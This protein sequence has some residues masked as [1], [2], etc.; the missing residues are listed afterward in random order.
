MEYVQGQSL[1][2]IARDQGPVPA[3]DFDAVLTGVAEALDA[4]HASGVVHGDVTPGNVL[5]TTDG[6][7]KLCDFGVGRLVGDDPTAP[8]AGTP[9][10]VAP[11]VLNGHAAGPR[12]DIYSLGALT[13]MMLGGRDADIHDLPPS[14]AAVVNSALAPVPEMRCATAGALAA[15][16]H[17]AV[18]E[19]TLQ[20]RGAV[21]R[22][23]DSL[24]AAVHR[25][26]PAM[27]DLPPTVSFPLLEE[28]PV[29]VPDDP[30]RTRPLPPATPRHGG[31]VTQPMPG[32]ARR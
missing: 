4:A 13:L 24:R 23:L 27:V 21:R 20:R 31:E 17:T 29:F 32:P 11:E 1:S 7:V 8:R 14:F 25:E 2:A 12:A 10:F 3:H 18:E 22:L 16:F 6:K 28:E 19:E 5:I 15:A 26:P 9:R 30:D